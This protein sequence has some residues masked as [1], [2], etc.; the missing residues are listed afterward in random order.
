[1]KSSWEKALPAPLWQFPRIVRRDRRVLGNY[2]LD[3]AELERCA[4]DRQGLVVDRCPLASAA[5]LVELIALRLHHGL[6]WVLVP[7]TFERRAIVR[8]GATEDNDADFPEADF[9]VHQDHPLYPQL[10]QTWL[11]DGRRALVLTYLGLGR[12][13]A[14]NPLA[15]E[16]V[17]SVFCPLVVI[18][19]PG[20][21]ILESFPGYSPSRAVQ[22]AL[23]KLG[24]RQVSPP[25]V[26]VTEKDVKGF[27]PS[28]VEKSLGLQGLIYLDGSPPRATNR[29]EAS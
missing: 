19:D 9:A 4:I 17:L 23:G 13:G 1:M 28:V 26:V 7:S 14:L 2:S 21:E 6:M 5:K 22:Q 16:P 29:P 12:R 15:R 11:K 20:L 8:P 3:A 24:A 18:V 10:P 25:V 27:F